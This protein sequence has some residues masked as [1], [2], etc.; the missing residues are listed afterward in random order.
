MLECLDELKGYDYYFQVTMTSYGK[1]IEPGVP[2]KRM[3]LDTFID[4]SKNIGKE[5]VI[6]RYDP[7]ILTNIYDE[8]YHYKYFERMVKKLSGHTDKCIIGFI[9]WYKKT[10]KNM[11]VHK[12]KNPTPAEKKKNNQKI[13]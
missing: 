12:T 3:V 1:D 8:A 13:S 9:D 2:P 6:W 10:E 11:K 7:I 5:K 4:L